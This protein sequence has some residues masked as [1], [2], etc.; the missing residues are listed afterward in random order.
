MARDLC[1]Y[2]FYAL[3]LFLLS[4]GQID[5]RSSD[6]V[7]TFEAGSSTSVTNRI[8]VM[9]DSMYETSESFVAVVSSHSQ[10]VSIQDPSLSTFTIIDDDSKWLSMLYKS[11]NGNAHM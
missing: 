10:G 7:L 11:T 6:S 3:L 9:D 1:C 4:V 8:S 2:N 5:F